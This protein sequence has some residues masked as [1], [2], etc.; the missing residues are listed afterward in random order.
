MTELKCP[1][2][3]ATL[4]IEENA[5]YAVC[6]SCGEK[7]TAKPQEAEASPAPKESPILRRCRLLIEDSEF[8]KAAA[9]CDEYLNENP[10]DAE[11][12]ELLFLCDIRNPGYKL[13]HNASWEINPNYQKI[14]RFGSEE[15]KAKYQK[16][17]DA[18]YQE[19]Q[20]SKNEELEAL[21]ERK[22]SF[23][24]IYG[25]STVTLSGYYIKCNCSTKRA[26]FTFEKMK[27][28]RVKR[29]GERSFEF[30]LFGREYNLG[31]NEV[32]LAQDLSTHVEAFARDVIDRI[33]LSGNTTCTFT[34]DIA[35]PIGDPEGWQATLAAQGTEQKPEP[36]APETKP[37]AGGCYVATCV[38]GSYNCPEV[39]TLRRYRDNNLASTWYGRLFIRTYYA[40]SPT[41]VKRFGNT[42]WFK[43]IC[44]GRLDRMV[45]KLRAKGIEDTPYED[46]NW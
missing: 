18:F 11:A 4:N 25:E 32:F 2:C 9:L 43:R 35:Q 16:L 39:W 5:E 27:N 36:Q 23:L 42:N 19:Q 33:K 34:G 13:V 38:Y 21:A 44:K 7:I 40:I 41:L 14:M 29:V 10:E 28:F 8:V 31:S 20:L 15:L 12:Y 6:T 37:K 17:K 24:G 46:K 3:E 1:K 26:I 22:Y 30:C 45:S